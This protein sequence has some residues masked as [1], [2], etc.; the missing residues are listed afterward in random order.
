MD[1]PNQCTLRELWECGEARFVVEGVECRPQNAEV[2][3]DSA[4][5]TERSV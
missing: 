4:L 3:V 1:T 2:G 5:L